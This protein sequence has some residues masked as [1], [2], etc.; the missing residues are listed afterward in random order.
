[1]TAHGHDD[2]RPIGRVLSRRDAVALLTS[3]GALAIIG[4]KPRSMAE[5]A[6]STQTA[7]SGSAPACVV[8]PEQTAGP[9]FVD[10]RLNRS[11]IRSDPS[12]DDAVVPGTPLQLTLNVSRLSGSACTALAGAI[13]DIWQCDALGVYSGVSDPQFDT[14]G[15]QFLRGHQLTDAKGIARFT[16]IYPGWYRGRAVHIHFRIRSAPLSERGHEFTSQLYFPEDVTDIVH[17]SPPYSEKG[18]RDRR[19]EQDGIYNRSGGSR[20]LLNPV[21]ADEGYSATFE[22]ALTTG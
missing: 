1:M 10:T 14:S 9:Y 20:L 21:R 12:R 3:A 19:N 16:T 11:D 6:D 22:V 17:A 4:C 5:A 8:R 15:Q 2:D 13:V 18:A 7:A